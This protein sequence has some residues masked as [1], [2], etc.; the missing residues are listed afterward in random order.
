MFRY[1]LNPEFDWSGEIQLMLD[2]G[3]PVTEP[4]LLIAEVAAATGVAENE[5]SE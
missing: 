4:D 5:G 1:I 3:D 2:R